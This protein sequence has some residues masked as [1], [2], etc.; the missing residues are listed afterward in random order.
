MR[1]AR[2]LPLLAALA[3]AAL[4]LSPLGS[5]ATAHAAALPLSGLAPL[6]ASGCPGG[7]T[8]G[9][10]VSPVGG[11]PFIVCTGRI[12]SFDGT[13]L[14]TDVTIPT[15][16]PTGTRPLMIFMHGWGN[17]KTDWEST[18]LAGDGGGQYHWNNAWF[19][20][21]GYVVLN[22]TARGFHASCGKDSGSSYLYSN[23]STCSDTTG[24]ASWTH[25]A[26]R[27]WETHDSQYLAGLLADAG[28]I[29]PQ[30]IVASG[31][32]Y[33][34]GQSWDLA[35]SQDQV[36]TSTSTDPAARI[37]C[38]GPRRWARHCTSWPRRRCIPG[39]I[40]ATRSF[41][42]AGPLTAPT[43]AP[44][45]ATTTTPSVSTSR[46]TWPGCSP[47]ARRARSTPRPGPT[48]PPT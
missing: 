39:P 5:P 40:S 2:R 7:M 15:A 12:R 23:D 4:P 18:T 31:G 33:G 47:A 9:P 46:R 34:G 19:A 28:L 44:P 14:D 16:T 24:E 29:N 37:W 30:K 35:L 8:A 13:P 6:T 3:F 38:R 41:R 27:R 42:T 45:T 25:L 11:Q 26:D 36:V 48:T 32:S 21:Q 20:S 17:S 10:P 43:A 22:Y 1:N